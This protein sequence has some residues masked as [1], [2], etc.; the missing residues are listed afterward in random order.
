MESW[1]KFKYN[2]EKSPPQATFF[3]TYVTV[4]NIQ[5]LMKSWAKVKYRSY[6]YPSRAKFFKTFVTVACHSTQI[7]SEILNEI[8]IQEQWKTAARKFFFKSINLVT[9][10]QKW[11]IE[12]WTKLK[13]RSNERPPQAKYFNSICHSRTQIM[14]KIMNEIEIQKFLNSICHSRT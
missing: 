7:I 1:K 8:E 12:S 14:N 11:L 3:T 6:E 9:V 10:V 13:Y 2:N 5:L 4:A